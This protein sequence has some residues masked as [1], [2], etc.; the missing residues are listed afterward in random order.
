MIRYNA[1]MKELALYDE[2]DLYDLVVTADAVAEA[3]YLDEAQRHGGRVLDLA[4]G[5]GRFTI[6]LAKAGIEVVGLD[7]SPTMLKRARDSATTAQVVIDWIEADMRD[8]DLGGRQFGMIMIAENSLLHLHS[9]ENIDR[10]FRTAARHLAPG[11]ALVF[12]IFVPGFRFLTRTS[13]QRHLIGHFHHESLGEITLEETSDYDSV[14]QVV[15]A[16]WFWSAKDRPDFLVTPMHLRQI[17]P[18]ELT[19]LVDRAGLRFAERYGYFD[20]SPF[21]SRGKQVCVCEPA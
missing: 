21:P 11:G 10:C 14:N 5:S 3:F 12:D 15:R 4:C 18:Q 1:A 20:R 16:T 17:F 9:I 19:L 8:F 6:P 7:S 13:D 2:P